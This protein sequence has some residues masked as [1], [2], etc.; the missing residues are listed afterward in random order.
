MNFNYHMNVRH[1]KIITAK[2]NIHIIIFFKGTNNFET[3]RN[4]SLKK[5][6]RLFQLN[7]KRNPFQI[8][9]SSHLNVNISRKNQLG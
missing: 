1:F 7:L 8:T 2:Y 3:T 4:I 6:S 9:F 5:C